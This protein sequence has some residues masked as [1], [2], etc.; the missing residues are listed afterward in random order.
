MMDPARDAG[1]SIAAL[2]RPGLRLLALF[3]GAEA[4]V[5][6]DGMISG[7]RLGTVRELDLA[8]LAP[9]G[10]HASSHGIGVAEALRLAE[11]LGLLPPVLRVFGVEVAPDSAD[12]LPADCVAAA[13]RRIFRALPRCAHC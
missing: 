12:S 13:A 11:T 2:D 1:W 3:E 7:A 10:H 4:V 6:V 8:D 9:L 5:I